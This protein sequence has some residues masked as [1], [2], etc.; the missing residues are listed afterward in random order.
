MSAINR[1][2]LVALLTSK[3][4]TASSPKTSAADV[5]EVMNA[6]IESLVAIIDDKDV[7]GGYLGIDENTG[8]VDNS[9]IDFPDTPGTKHFNGSNSQPTGIAIAFNVPL[10][11]EA[12]AYLA[13]QPYNVFVTPT[14]ATSAAFGFYV[15]VKQPDHFEVRYTSVPGGTTFEIDFVIIP[16]H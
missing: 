7:N 4:K 13:G 12:V 15:S 14:N 16:N 9:F 2:A 1:A 8:K 6:C 3:I 5:R 10:P 11:A